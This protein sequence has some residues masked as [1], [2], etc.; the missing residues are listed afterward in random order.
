MRA[1]ILQFGKFTNTRPGLK[2]HPALDD[3]PDVVEFD[4]YRWWVRLTPNPGFNLPLLGYWSRARG[5]QRPT[6]PWE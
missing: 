4:D 5:R 3:E 1:L 2:G 6:R